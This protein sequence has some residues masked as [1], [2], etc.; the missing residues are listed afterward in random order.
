MNANRRN[1]LK[2]K[3]LGTLARE[4]AKLQGGWKQGFKVSRFQGFKVS[5]FQ[6]FKVSRFQDGNG[7]AA[8]LK[9]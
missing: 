4:R 8:S 6:G 3:R 5:R 7:R 2:I 9:H 1:S